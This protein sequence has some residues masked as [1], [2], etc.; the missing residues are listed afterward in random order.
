MS[1]RPG[2]IVRRGKVALILCE[3]I[4]HF[5]PFRAVDLCCRFS[6]LSQREDP[7]SE[8]P[9]RG[10]ACLLMAAF[11]G[12]KLVDRLPSESH[13]STLMRCVR[14]RELVMLLRALSNNF[15]YDHK[16]GLVTSCLCAHCTAD[17]LSL[18]V[19]SYLLKSKR[20]LFNLLLNLFDL[21]LEY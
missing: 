8:E 6:R 16:Y 5:V 18:Y 7:K 12:R 14:C 11:L 17:I 4:F 10:G 13:R 1:P 2:K 3:L 20:F 21:D 19:L 9:L 15:A